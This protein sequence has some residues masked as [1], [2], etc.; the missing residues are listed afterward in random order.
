LDQINGTTQTIL[1]SFHESGPLEASHDTRFVSKWHGASA[2]IKGSSSRLEKK[3][4]FEWHLLADRVFC[5]EM[6]CLNVTGWM[7][8]LEE[9]LFVNKMLFVEQLY[10][11]M[12]EILLWNHIYPQSS[13]MKHQLKQQQ[14]EYQLS[15]SKLNLSNSLIADL[16]KDFL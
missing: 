7:S 4:G 15:W 14:N 13:N 10:R 12:N 3:G 1:Y 11:K 8:K 9:Q 5:A 6:D 2:Q 16:E